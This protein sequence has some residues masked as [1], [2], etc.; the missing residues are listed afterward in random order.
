[1][2]K[3]TENSG[4]HQGQFKPGQ[5]GNPSG[6][7]KGARNK[8]TLALEALLDGEAEALTKKAI[9]LAKG[10][11]LVALRLCMDRLLPPRKDRPVSLD[12]PGIDSTRDVPKA[13]SALLS[14]VAAGELA[15]SDAAEVT[16]LLDAYGRAVE[17]NE[18]AERIDN[19]EKMAERP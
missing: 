11:D 19:L 1:M 2:T 14:A 17:I 15:P 6:K 9:E 5:S 16:K 18:L 8:V 12:L 3:S 4:R 13:I 10:G 7:P